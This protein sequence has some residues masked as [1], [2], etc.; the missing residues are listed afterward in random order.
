MKL[1]IT[2]L[3]FFLLAFN[4]AFSQESSEMYKDYNPKI[5]L[6]VGAPNSYNFYDYTKDGSV[7]TLTGSFGISIPIHTIKTPYL[8]IPIQINYSTNGVKLN[9]L[10]NEIGINWNILAGGEINRIVNKVPDDREKTI[11]RSASN[12]Y[13]DANI[14]NFVWQKFD[15]A[16]VRPTIYNNILPKSSFQ[17][18]E[19]NTQTGLLVKGAGNSTCGAFYVNQFP[20]SMNNFFFPDHAVNTEVECLNEMHYRENGIDDGKDSYEVDTELDY[21]KVNLNGRNFTFVIK[22]T[23]NY[24]YN[25]QHPNNSYSLMPNTILDVFEAVCLDD[26]GYKIEMQYGKIPFYYSNNKKLGRWMEAA[27]IIK[28]VITD[29]NGVRYIF[30]KL[31]LNDN[32]YL[33]EFYNRFIYSQPNY[34]FMQMKMFDTSAD[35]WKL[36]KIVLPNS[37][38]VTFTYDDNKYC[39]SREIVRQHDGEYL[40]KPY[41]L[42][43]SKPNY[44]FDKLETYVSDYV[45]KEISYNNQKVK[46]SYINNRP[47]LLMYDF[48]KPSEDYRK[49]LSQISI[50]DPAG[51]TIRKFDFTKT[52]Y[53]YQD[54]DESHEYSRMFLTK[55]EDSNKERSY[56]FEYDSPEK[57]F[58]RNDVRGH[59]LYGYQNGNTLK[60]YPSFPK[61]YINLNDNYGN[62][63][64]YNKPIVS[65]YFETTGVDRSPNTTTAKYGTLK[66]VYFKTG[67]S[68]GI[69]YEN[70][71]FFDER[72]FSKKELGPGVRVK[73][74]KYYSEADKLE[75]RID[76]SYD[77]FNDNSISGGRLLYKPSFAYFK[78]H[79]FNNEFDKASYETKGLLD[80]KNFD[81]R[82][83]YNVQNDFD[84]YFTK[85]TL[86]KTTS[87]T[88][89]QIAKKMLHFS[90]YSLG[91]T[92]DIY[93]RELIYVN[94]SMK[95]IDVKNPISNLG[96]T[97]YT[98]NYNDNRGFVG[99]VTGFRADDSYLYTLGNVDSPKLGTARP[100][101]MPYFLPDYSPQLRT[102]KGFIEKDAKEI[103]PFPQRNFFEN[104]ENARFGK[105]KKIEFF[106]NANQLV[107]SEEYTYDY[108]KKPSLINNNNILT[109]IQRNILKMHQYFDNDPEKKFKALYAQYITYTQSNYQNWNGMHLFSLN[110]LRYN[111]KIDIKNKKTTNYFA[112]NKS[113]ENNSVYSYD[114][115]TGNVSEVM[116]TESNLD[117]IKVTYQYPNPVDDGDLLNV[118]W[119]KNAISE[120]HTIRKYVKNAVTETTRKSFLIQNAQSFP[121]LSE[122]KKSKS[123]VSE[124]LE[125]S[126]IQ[127]KKYNSKDLPAE[128]LTKEGLTIS[129]L[130]GYDKTQ[131]VAKIENIAYSAIPSSLINNIETASSSTGSETAMLTALTALRNDPALVS[132]MVTTY[133]HIPLVGIST[134]TDPKGDK[135]TYIYDTLGRLEFVK[136]K[137]GNILSENQYNYKQ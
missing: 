35:N 68:L 27:A 99:G 120:P 74:L 6:S 83:E 113:L 93:G 122:V 115:D 3:T 95:I 84:N 40:N 75:K 4:C 20:L 52:F 38:E 129:Y 64:S 127:I 76:Y 18:F 100:F 71:T 119:S 111:S 31:V 98:Y 12:I 11:V 92:S 8:D 21:F 47:D 136:D 57:L 109:N 117:P 78:N 118:L 10:S 105:L 91:S 90:N 94:V 14:K 22:K 97:R 25:I 80:I 33:R 43:P 73:S 5:D 51:K 104:L 72:L 126:Q 15:P 86:E 41:N 131:L 42:Q 69:D 45:L 30:D 37:D 58:A 49:N 54:D 112:D 134:I 102:S 132:A 59:D 67:G 13:D 26:I 116:I 7:N 125:S 137:N 19:K 16:D 23:D 62:K 123:L 61:L 108:V 44:G 32:E 56:V 53:N 133:T 70:N 128:I 96:E 39:Y 65:D 46:F 9:T 48:T 124:N 89:M 103:F 77:D 87:L 121:L 63:I 110:K 29:K 101:F 24:F 114:T 135:T 55:I 34:R 2:F 106:N 28:F 66:N 79:S 50:V 130:Y 107:S 17:Y 1:K 36:T 88:Q 85:E 81:H 60:S 82:Y